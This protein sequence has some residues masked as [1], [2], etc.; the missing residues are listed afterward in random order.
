MSTNL[1]KL[2][3]SVV[4][5]TLTTLDLYKLEKLT[6]DFQSLHKELFLESRGPSG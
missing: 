1:P 2:P 4:K 5:S 6:E 3:C